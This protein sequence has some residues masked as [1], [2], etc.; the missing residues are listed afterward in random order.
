[1]ESAAAA[2]ADEFEIEPDTQK[3]AARAAKACLA[4]SSYGADE[5]DLL[6]SVGQYRSG[7]IAEPAAATMTA[8]D[9]AMNEDSEPLDEKRT[10]AFDVL[11]GPL[12]LLN[13]CCLAAG[14][15]Q[16]G[17]SR[18]VMVVASETQDHG[19]DCPPR[20]QAAGAALI[21]DRPLQGDIGFGP[22]LFKDYPQHADALTASAD[23]RAGQPRVLVQRSPDL[24]DRYVKCIADAVDE[25][26]HRSGMSRSQIAA[27]FPPQ[28][29]PAFVA[30]LGERLGFDKARVVDVSSQRGD[31]FTS[32]IPYALQRAQ[33]QQRIGPGEI[34]LLIAVSAG[35]QV[36]CALYHF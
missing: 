25:L 9:L 35:I 21:L 10:L 31:L 26:L 1:V 29:S 23:L 12:G 3:L 8:C 6:L 34:G 28:I 17:K 24:E 33:E 13:A 27:V 22:F 5:I 16:A 19:D 4:K 32:S 7:F 36:G 2:T 20:R 11:N 15:I 18:H 30:R 14:L